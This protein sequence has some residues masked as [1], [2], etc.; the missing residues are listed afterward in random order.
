MIAAQE[1]GRE[2]VQDVSSIVKYALAYR[3][4]L[5]G[6][7]ERSEEREKAGLDTER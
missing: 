7:L 3:A 4:S 5:A 6:Q 2:T 1:I